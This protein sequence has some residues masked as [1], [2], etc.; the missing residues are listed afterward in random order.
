MIKT[1]ERIQAEYTAWLA[2]IDD[3]LAREAIT[4]DQY[5]DEFYAGVLNFE[6]E[7]IRNKIEKPIFERIDA[8]ESKSGGLLGPA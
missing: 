6:R 7:L 3:N 5:F 8:L 4:M 1:K 2:K